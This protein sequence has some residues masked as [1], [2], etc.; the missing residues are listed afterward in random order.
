MDEGLFSVKPSAR[1]T[2]GDKVRIQT[3][4]GMEFCDVMDVTRDDDDWPMVTLRTL[5]G[6]KITINIARVERVEEPS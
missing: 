2:R 1:L 5:S 4:W 3:I 6:D